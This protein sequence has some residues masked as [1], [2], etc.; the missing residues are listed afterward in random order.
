[1]AHELP[2]PAIE[3]LLHEEIVARIAYI[4]RLGRPCIV[5]ITYAYDGEALYGYSLMGA[6]I[7][8]MSTHPSVSVEVDQV[9][10]SADWCSVIAR[11]MFEP[12]DGHAAIEA[13]ERIHD[14]LRTVA[15]AEHD[16]D[17]A[18]QTFVGREGGPGL[19]YRIRLA[20]KHGRCSA[21]A[22]IR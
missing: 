4:D 1:M 9:H 10:S 19:A 8:G 2:A 6:K 22:S 18:P 21:P 20:E 15:Q 13:V 14:R 3:S 17:S 5:P 7:E 12:L 16:A 11:G